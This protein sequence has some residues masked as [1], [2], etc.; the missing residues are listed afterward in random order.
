MKVFALLREKIVA[1]SGIGVLQRQNI[2]STTSE[3]PI[4]R[5]KIGMGYSERSKRSESICLG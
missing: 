5:K 1:A 3:Y 4:F 2:A